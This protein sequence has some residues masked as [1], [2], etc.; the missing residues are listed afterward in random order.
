MK[1]WLIRVLGGVTA[2]EFSEVFSLAAKDREVIQQANEF[3]KLQ[4]EARQV[5]IDYLEN[6]ILA[7]TGF[8]VSPNDS[9]STGHKDFAPIGGQNT[10]G[11]VKHQLELRDHRLMQER[12]KNASH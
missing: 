4:C 11:K 12:S 8:V 1:N 2:S 5:R 6:L 3:Y 7:K 10:W 9:D